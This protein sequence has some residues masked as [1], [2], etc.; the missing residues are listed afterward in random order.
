MSRKYLLENGLPLSLQQ[1]FIDGLK[2]LD[3]LHVDIC[4]PSH[5]NQ[6]GIVPL[7]GEITDEFNPFLD[8]SIWHELMQERIGRM[9]QMMA[10]EKESVLE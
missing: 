7:I 8:E 4:L 5:T 10:Q 6:V 2:K 9:E 1:E 3:Q